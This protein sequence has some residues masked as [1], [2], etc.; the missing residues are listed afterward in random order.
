[1][2]SEGSHPITES[3]RFL[4]DLILD[5]VSSAQRAIPLEQTGVESDA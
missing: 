2:W 4:F 5:Q 1:M 3:F